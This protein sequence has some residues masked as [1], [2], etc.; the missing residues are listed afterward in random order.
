MELV[1]EFPLIILLT[2][3]NKIVQ[4][5]DCLPGEVHEE[6]NFVTLYA[7]FGGFLCAVE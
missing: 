7:G 2:Q 4:F 6:K 1:Y 3:T 5:K